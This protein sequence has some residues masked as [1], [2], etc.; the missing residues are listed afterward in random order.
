MRAAIRNLGRA[1]GSY[2]C[3]AEVMGVPKH[4]VEHAASTSRVSYK[5]AVLVARA[6]GTTVEALLSPPVAADR[7]P[8][9]NTRRAS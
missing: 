9:C 3:L 1:Y 5:Y 6:A 4:S 8:T 2:A 7:C